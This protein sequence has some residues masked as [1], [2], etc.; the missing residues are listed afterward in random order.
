LTAARSFIVCS[1]ALL[2]ALAG[3][4][5][6]ARAVSKAEY[7]AELQK[8]GRDLTT[9]GQQLGRSIDV[10][11]FTRS[12]DSLQ[13]HLRAAAKELDGLEPPKDVRAANKRLAKAFRALA[14]AFEPVK[15]ARLKNIVEA[16]NALAR[17][18][19]ASAVKDGRLAI[20]LLQE[21]GY[22][23]AGLVTP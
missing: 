6:S 7:Q 2:V 23:V 5:S 10:A 15:D 8:L 18:G 19:A 4:G 3:C 16:R 20:H 9:A 14:D 12:V 22:D 21:R 1:A 13:K 11:T 17:V